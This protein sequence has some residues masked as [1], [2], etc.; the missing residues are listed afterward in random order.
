MILITQPDGQRWKSGGAEVEP[1]HG[2]LIEKKIS[3]DTFQ[4]YI[5]QV[6]QATEK[7]GC[8]LQMRNRAENTAEKSVCIRLRRKSVGTLSRNISVK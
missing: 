5:S 6:M 7:Y 1:G 3:V 8:Q 2:G 4:K